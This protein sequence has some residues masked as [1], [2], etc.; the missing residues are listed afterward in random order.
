MKRRGVAW[1]A[2]SGE[3]DGIAGVAP[4]V[5]RVESRAIPSSERRRLF[6]DGGDS[7]SSRSPVSAVSSV[8]SSSNPLRSSC[9]ASSIASLPSSPRSQTLNAGGL[10]LGGEK[11][12]ASCAFGCANVN[13]GVAANFGVEAN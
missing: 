5:A 12:K 2:G 7:D 11:G 10:G 4:N 3:G 13:F 9:D 1:L 6:A 8:T